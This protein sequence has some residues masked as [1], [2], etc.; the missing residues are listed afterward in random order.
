MS[1][2][3]PS[4]TSLASPLLPPHTKL[5][6]NDIELPSVAAPEKA[7]WK[8]RSGYGLGHVQNDMAGEDYCLQCIRNHNQSSDYN[9]HLGAADGYRQ[10]LQRYCR[11][12]CCNLS[13]DLSLH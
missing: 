9:Y 7:S 5:D 6:L 1:D 4:L 13:L 3:S 2:Y 8:L 12:S 11:S 10:T